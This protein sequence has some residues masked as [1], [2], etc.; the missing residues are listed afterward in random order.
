MQFH[1]SSSAS[2]CC[3][4]CGT[5]GYCNHKLNVASKIFSNDHNH[6]SDNAIV[7][8]TVAERAREA[9]SK[10]TVEQRFKLYTDMVPA[11][12]LPPPPPTLLS[13]FNV[14]SFNGGSYNNCCFGTSTSAQPVVSEEEE[15]EGGDGGGSR[16]EGN[17]DSEDSVVGIQS[18]NHND[19]E[20]PFEDPK[21]IEQCLEE[22]DAVICNMKPTDKVA[23]E[24]AKSISKDYVTSKS[25]LLS[26]LRADQFNIN[27]TAKRIVSH[28]EMKKELFVVK[29]SSIRGGFDGDLS[30]LGRDIERSDLSSYEL[31]L[32]DA[33]GA[34]LFLKE[35]DHSGRYVLRGRMAKFDYQ[36]P[37]CQVRTVFS[38]GVN[39]EE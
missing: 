16:N 37:I 9:M 29:T 2:F 12:P 15:E 7:D 13:S 6:G 34:F 11:P 39:E 33:G 28:F 36:H 5:I 25:F 22:L 32:L 3:R 1:S 18:C 27:D 17:N 14:K 10:L 4:E 35:P 19:V 38:M 26:F 23:Y 21:H 24:E 8:E 20:L 31:D 30:I